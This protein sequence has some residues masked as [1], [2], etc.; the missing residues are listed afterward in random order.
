MIISDKYK[1]IF[2]RIPKTGSTSIENALKEA[3][4][5]CISSNNSIPPYGHYSDIFVKQLAGEHRWN[6]YFKFCTFRDPID[7]FLS[8]YLDQSF[9]SLSEAYGEMYWFFKNKDCSLPFD[10]ENP[11]INEHDMIKM[12]VLNQQWLKPHDCWL[13]KNWIRSGEMD[14]I[15]DLKDLNRE[16]KNLKSKFGFDVDILKENVGDLRENTISIGKK[17]RFSKEAEEIF[18]ILYRKDI[19]FY[20]NLKNEKRHKLGA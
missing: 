12:H 6:N 18:S 2:I 9:Y 7:W 4:P 16:W 20:K 11:I 15:I 19:E 13:Q 17:P 1:L 10:I 14:L 8:M 3:D 5:H